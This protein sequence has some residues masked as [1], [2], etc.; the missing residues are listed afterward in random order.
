MTDRHF[1]YGELAMIEYVIR[2]WGCTRCKYEWIPKTERPPKFCPGCNSPYWN[3]E[4]TR[5]I[6]KKA[7]AKRRMVI[8]K[9]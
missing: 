2:K 4:R 5:T 7:Q 8:V 3:K 1:H 6:P 9:R